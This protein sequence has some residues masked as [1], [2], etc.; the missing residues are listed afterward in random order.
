MKIIIKFGFENHMAIK[1]KEKEKEKEKPVVATTLQGMKNMRGKKEESS[2]VRLLFKIR[3]SIFDP[4][5]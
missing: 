1:E 2:G 3:V 5:I 4:M